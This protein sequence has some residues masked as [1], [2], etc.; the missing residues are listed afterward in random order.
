M[1]DVIESIPKP[2]L[3]FKFCMSK[4]FIW[5]I[6]SYRKGVFVSALGQHD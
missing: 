4:V 6:G 2:I 3:A 5:L 1:I